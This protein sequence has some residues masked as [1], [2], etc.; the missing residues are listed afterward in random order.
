MQQQARVQQSRETVVEKREGRYTQIKEYSPG[1]RTPKEAAYVKHAALIV[2][3][4]REA[5]VSVSST[6]P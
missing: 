2:E 4:L 6:R 3:D 1:T 5:A